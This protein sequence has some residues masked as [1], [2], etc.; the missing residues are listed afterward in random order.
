[1]AAMSTSLT[2]FSTIGDKRVYTLSGHTVSEP[3]IVICKRV[4]PTGNKTNS[5]FEASVIYA[6]K[7]ADGYVLPQRP[8]FTIS[9]SQPIQGDPSDVTAMLAIIRDIVAGDE[10]ANSVTTG[11]FLA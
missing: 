2:E 6:T 7:D 10:Y 4:V 11:E 5:V 3:K 8:T 9:C 1:M